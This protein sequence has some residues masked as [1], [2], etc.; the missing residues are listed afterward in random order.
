MMMRLPVARF[1]AFCLLSLALFCAQ[2]AWAL[3]I[4][5]TITLEGAPARLVRVYVSGI[6]TPVFTDSAGEFSVTVPGAGEYTV[7][8][9]PRRAFVVTPANRKIVV[10][11]TSVHE[12]NFTLSRVAER[13]ALRGRLYSRDKA[14]LC[15]AKVYLSGA[16]SVLT[17]ANGIFQFPSLAAGRYFVTPIAP[18]V[19]FSS[20]V[21]GR[22]LRANKVKTISFRALPVPEGST[23]PSYLSGVYA[24]EISLA[25][26]C[27]DLGREITGSAKVEQHGASAVVSLPGLGSSRLAATINGFAGGIAKRR[28][29]CRILGDLNANYTNSE[30]ASLAGSF[31]VSCFGDTACNSSFT[32]SLTRR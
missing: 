14:P 6:S 2:S 32:G 16:D 15:N 17:D 13:A 31:S 22:L 30:N 25:Q 23:I 18:G 21:R 12:A 4:S 24:V 20:P 9:Y 11:N 28:F 1:C 10:G 26:P 29:G 5:G 3:K 7:S 8:P 19:I 27:G